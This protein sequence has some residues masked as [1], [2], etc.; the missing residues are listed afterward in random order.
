MKVFLVIALL[1][2]AAT[3][4]SAQTNEE[5]AK[6][7]EPC[8]LTLVQIP[9]ING[10]RLGMTPDEVL[11]LFPGSREDAEL[12][13]QLSKPATQFGAT[14]FVISP[15]KYKSKDKFA[16][17][18]RIAFTLLDGRVYNF[19]LT[20]RGPQ[21]DHV[22]KFVESFVAGK[23]LPAVDD[24]EPYVGMDDQLKVL[25]CSGF[26]IR[27]FAGRQAGVLNYIMV[28]DLGEEQ[29]LKER[30]ARAREKRAEAA[31]P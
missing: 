30:K 29:K 8:N 21:Y 31:K 19:S 18:S 17:I 2:I 28:K 24:W 14:D 26:E 23:N 11:A 16:G 9:A 22:D 27:A 20:Y 1:I 5:G 25:R 12:R 4:V 10:L 15:D 7:K 3:A 13:T 6:S